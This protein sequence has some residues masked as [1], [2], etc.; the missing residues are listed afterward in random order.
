MRRPRGCSERRRC[1]SPKMRCR[2]IFG[3][4]TPSYA[5][6]DFLAARLSGAGVNFTVT[7][8]E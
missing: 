7:V 4:L 1:V 6:G 5:M 8:R 3:V 2:I